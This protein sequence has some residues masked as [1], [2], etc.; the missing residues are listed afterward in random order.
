MI[1]NV[2]KE[3]NKKK[4]DIKIK[5]NPEKSNKKTTIKDRQNAIRN[6]Q[7]MCIIPPSKGLYEF[8][9]L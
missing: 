1:S 6:D 2:I 3:R 7:R 4:K 8:V 5:E 9:N